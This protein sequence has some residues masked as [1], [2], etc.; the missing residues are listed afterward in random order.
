MLYS[1]CSDVIKECYTQMGFSLPCCEETAAFEG[2]TGPLFNLPAYTQMN[3]LSFQAVIVLKFPE[4]DEHID[5]GTFDPIDDM[6]IYIMGSNKSFTN[7]EFKTYYV[8]R[9]TSTK[10]LISKTILNAVNDPPEFTCI[11]YNVDNSG[12]M[13]EIH[14]CKSP[15][16]IS[17]SI[18]FPR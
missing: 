16:A 2:P 6:R 15:N 8:A 12:K 11:N 14:C 5:G 10:L 18:N 3:A 9:G 1:Q 17:S 4:K 7:S 13:L